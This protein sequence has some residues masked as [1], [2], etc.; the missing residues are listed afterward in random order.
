[1][2]KVR[3]DGSTQETIDFLDF[4]EP[5]ASKVPSPLKAVLGGKQVGFRY[6]HPL[7]SDASSQ[8]RYSFWHSC[9]SMGQPELKPAFVVL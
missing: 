4:S 7:K 3:I 6:L 1:V 5:E 9:Q 2:P 8:V